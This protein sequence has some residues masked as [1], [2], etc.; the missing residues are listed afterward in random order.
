MS[1]DAY[2]LLVV[3]DRLREIRDLPDDQ[4]AGEYEDEIEALEQEQRDLEQR[5]GDE[6]LGLQGYRGGPG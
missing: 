3:A 6:V 4:M 2:R 5:L 1:P